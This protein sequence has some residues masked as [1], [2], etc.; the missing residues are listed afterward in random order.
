MGLHWR[1]QDPLC[2]AEASWR[3]SNELWENRRNAKIS[4]ALQ[5]HTRI[6]FRLCKHPSEIFKPVKVNIWWPSTA[7]FKTP[8]SQVHPLPFPL[9]QLFK[10]LFSSIGVASFR[11]LCIMSCKKWE[12]L[13]LLE[14]PLSGEHFLRGYHYVQ[15][16]AGSSLRLTEVNLIS[17][18]KRQIIGHFFI[19][20]VPWPLLWLESH[21][22]E[23]SPTMGKGQKTALKIKIFDTDKII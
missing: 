12:N 11:P 4:R 22:M 7:Y 2:R 23:Q 1:Y 16:W 8:I 20:D 5:V 15:G 13:H 9:W 18:L 17:L 3:G 14:M 6:F 10:S 19:A 21:L